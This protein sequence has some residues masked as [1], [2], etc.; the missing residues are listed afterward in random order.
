MNPTAPQR[1]QRSAFWP[2]CSSEGSHGILEFMPV[3]LRCP[4][5]LF[6]LLGVA[7]VFDAMTEPLGAVL[8]RAY[9]TRNLRRYPSALTPSF[10][11]IFLPS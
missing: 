6:L 11:L 10:Q 3:I 1:G 5:L 4:R 2:G 8:R 7:R 9:M